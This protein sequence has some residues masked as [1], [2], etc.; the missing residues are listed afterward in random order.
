MIVLMGNGVDKMGSPNMAYRELMYDYIQNSFK[1]N[2]DLREKYDDDFLN[3]LSTKEIESI[4]KRINPD[5]PLYNAM[6]AGCI[7]NNWEQNAC[8]D[9]INA[10]CGILE[11]YFNLF[12]IKIP[13]RL[14]FK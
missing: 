4:V 2:K 13:K 14:Y 12:N 7:L 3:S 1:S 5:T 8:I 6:M 9:Q 11:K 10:V